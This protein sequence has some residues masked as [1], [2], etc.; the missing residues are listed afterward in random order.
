MK[1]K[2]TLLVLA[3]GMGSRYGG[4]KQVD[5]IGPGGETITDYSVYDAKRAG[6]DKVV[7][8]I[9]K[10]IEAD[11]KE[12]FQRLEKHIEVEYVF[13]ELD[14]IP[15]GFQI[16]PDRTKPWGTGH[17]V[18]VAREAID[19]PFAVINADDFYGARSY[20]VVANF[21]KNPEIS[22]REKYCMVGF[23]LKN[24][25]SEFGHVS[26]GVCQ[27]DSNNY[28][29]GIVE[30]TKIQYTHDK[31]GIIYFDENDQPH[32]LIGNETVSMN[33]WGFSTEIFDYLES[34]FLHFIKHNAHNIKA[35]FY[36]PSAINELIAENKIN[37]S[38]LQSPD[39]WFGVTY[40]EDKEITIKRIKQLIHEGIYPEQLW[41]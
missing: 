13:Q 27:V 4:L 37:V 6:F 26:R 40:K 17:A 36:L 31:N 21:L 8:V 1:D 11:F 12:I 41:A 7:F 29:K 15:S 28:L 10:S 39:N 35:E 30:R 18:W 22:P 33:F 38:V 23:P 14:A 2:I 20:Q 9:R 34:Q 19:T 24:T 32:K 16:H 25:L 5:K 3:A